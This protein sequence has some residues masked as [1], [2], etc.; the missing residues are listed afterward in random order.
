MK[1]VIVKGKVNSILPVTLLGFDGWQKDKGAF[2]SWSAAG[3]DQLD[4]FL[5]ERKTT[6]GNFSSIHRIQS[7]GLAANSKYE[8]FDMFSNEG[9]VFYR[10]KMVDRDGSFS[11]SLVVIVKHKWETGF[12]I[13]HNPAASTVT[14]VH[15]DG[16][17]IIEM[18]VVNAA[19]QIVHRQAVMAGARQST[20][21]VQSLKAG[22][23]NLVVKSKSRIRVAGFIKL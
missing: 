4:Y 22:L 12:K 18:Q 21:N 15:A 8:Y 13:F 3:N 9:D 2:L 11:Y 19:G 6:D 20:I 7:S 14:V 23:Y 16:D 17:D 1:D 10:L 5:V